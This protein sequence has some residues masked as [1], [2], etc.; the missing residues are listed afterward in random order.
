MIT[1]RTAAPPTP[2]VGATAGAG[3]TWPNATPPAA[4]RPLS[5]PTIPM[6]V[7]QPKNADPHRIR[8]RCRACSGA[9]FERA[10]LKVWKGWVRSA[11]GTVL[12]GVSSL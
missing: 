12:M 11:S 8:P 6:A 10:W 5:R 4:R 1:S 7:T 3:F 2:M 9:R